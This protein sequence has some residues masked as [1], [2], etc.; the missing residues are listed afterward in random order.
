MTI[1]MTLRNPLDKSKLLPV[2]IEPNDTQL[3]KDWVVALQDELHRNSVLEKNYCWH[4]W[5]N[6]QRNL[7]YLT[8]ELSRHTTRVDNFNDTNIWQSVGLDPYPLVTHYTPQLVMIPLTGINESGK[9]GG[10]PNHDVMNIVHNY[11]EHLQGTVENLSPYYKLASPEVKYSI[12][13]INNLCHEIET[14]C[15]SIRKAHYDPQW[16]RPSQITTFLNARRHDL[17]PEHRQGFIKNG[18]DRRFAHIYMHWTQIGKTL[19]EVFR[20]EGAPELDKATCD[21]ITH[22]QYYSGEFDIEW[23]RDVC[24]GIHSWHTD[25]QDRYRAWLVREG[26]SPS[27]TN[28]SLGYLE[29][30][31]IDTQRSFGTNDVDKIWEMMGDYLDIYSITVDGVTAVYDYSWADVDHEERQIAYLMPGYRSHV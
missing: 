22:L 7:E 12:R 28:L 20:D 4:G 23:G 13:Q 27:D 15:L 26:Y 30:A 21:A 11:F 5:P 29:L 31:R 25:E 8:R 14:L 17:T 10:G 1:I 19:M 9:R 3:A 6:S 2:Y 16:V 18:Y 24:Y